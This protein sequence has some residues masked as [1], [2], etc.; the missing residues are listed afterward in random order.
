MGNNMAPANIPP[1]QFLNG[2]KKEKIAQSKNEELQQDA[3]ALAEMLLRD[4]EGKKPTLRN[5]AE[6]LADKQKWINKFGR[7]KATTIERMKI[8]PST[9]KRWK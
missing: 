3:N 6:E 9:I 2:E 8:K 7:D 1:P 4:P 5:I